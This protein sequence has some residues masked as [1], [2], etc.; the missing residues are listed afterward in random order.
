[1]L[2]NEGVVMLPLTRAD[3]D[4]R[5]NSLTKYK[6]KKQFERGNHHLKKNFDVFDGGKYRSQLSSTQAVSQPV[7]KH[8][9][10]VFDP[11]RDAYGNKIHVPADYVK[12]A[13]KRYQ[14]VASLNVSNSQDLID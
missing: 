6:M 8:A 1:M 5:D 4:L 9:D 10:K 12:T 11:Y 13:G 2:T 7:L 14:P 3:A